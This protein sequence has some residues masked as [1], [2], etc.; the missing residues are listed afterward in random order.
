MTSLLC[1]LVVAAILLALDELLDLLVVA[2]GQGGDLGDAVA[3]PHVRLRACLC[4][5]RVVR[6]ALVRDD[7][8]LKAVDDAEVGV[9]RGVDGGEHDVFVAQ[10][11]SCLLGHILELPGRMELE[12]VFRHAE[13]FRVESVLHVAN[14][15]EEGVLCCFDESVDEIP[16]SPLEVGYDLVIGLHL[17][18]LE[19][20]EIVIELRIRILQ[21]TEL[22]DR[23]VLS[24]I[25]ELS[26]ESLFLQIE[27]PHERNAVLVALFP[28]TFECLNKSFSFLCLRAV[29]AFRCFDVAL[30]N[31]LELLLH[32]LDDLHPEREVGELALLWVLLQH[33]LHQ[34]VDALKIRLLE[35]V[36]PLSLLFMLLVF[37]LLPPLLLQNFKELL[38]IV[39]TRLLHFVGVHKAVIHIH[40]VSQVCYD[41]HVVLWVALCA[42]VSRHVE[43]L[44]APEWAQIVDGSRS[45]SDEVVA[46][47]QAVEVGQRV[48]VFELLDAIVEQAEVC[49]LDQRLEALYV[50]DVVEGQVQPL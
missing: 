1:M 46:N 49:Q 37:L 48:E 34:R 7:A 40:D 9:V 38:L 29:G 26:Q 30:G 43:H 20:Q 25:L 47:G 44:E 21:L 23:L 17:S 36:Q 31:A 15:G 27:F 10:N 6:L 22:L 19:L 12:L 8:V 11:H 41:A 35:L 33:V 13:R 4:N 3:V 5:E 45:I 39:L 32:L 24:Q 18:Q 2:R 14:L 28:A 50:L 16:V 42:R